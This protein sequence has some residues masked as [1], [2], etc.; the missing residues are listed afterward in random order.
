MIMRRIPKQKLAPEWMKMSISFLKMSESGSCVIFEPPGVEI[1]DTGSELVPWARASPDTLFAR[2]V[3]KAGSPLAVVEAPLV[4]E[5][6]LDFSASFESELALALER[7]LDR[8][9]MPCFSLWAS[10]NFS[11]IFKIV[12]NAM[13]AL[14]R[15]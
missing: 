11:S 3:S 12:S 4:D 2:S 9:E 7:S 1:R 8:V 15:R 13:Y 10:I 6:M 14:R 5:A